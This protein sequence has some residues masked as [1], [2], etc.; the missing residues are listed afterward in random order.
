MIV[1]PISICHG[2]ASG[3]PTRAMKSE[4]TFRAIEA[5]YD[6]PSKESFETVR[7]TSIC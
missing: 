2:P 5:F 3:R 4:R 6:K 7:C 1:G